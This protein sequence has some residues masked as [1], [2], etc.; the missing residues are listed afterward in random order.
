MGVRIPMVSKNIR[1]EKIVL[2]FRL[3]K[4]ELNALKRALW[5][6][7]LAG[8]PEF[9]VSKVGR[10]EVEVV[11]CGAVPPSE[12]VEKIRKE[13]LKE[14]L[15][16]RVG[17]LEKFAEKLGRRI[18][19][20]KK[21]ALRVFP[22]VAL[23]V[24]GRARTRWELSRK[25]ARALEL[26]MEDGRPDETAGLQ[27]ILELQ[28]LGLI[29]PG[30]R[31]G[32]RLTE[33]GREKLKEFASKG[34]DCGIEEAAEAL[35]GEE[36]GEG[37]EEGKAEYQKEE[38]QMIDAEKLSAVKR[39]AEEVIGDGLKAEH[40]ETLELFYPDKTLTIFEVAEKSG[41]THSGA[42]AILKRLKSRGFLSA[43]EA[44][45]GKLYYYLTPKGKLLMEGFAGAGA[46]EIL[47]LSYPDYLPVLF[48][49]KDGVYSVK[50]LSKALEL[51][52]NR[53]GSVLRRLRAAGLIRSLGFGDYKI[54]NKGLRVLNRAK[55]AGLWE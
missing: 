31:Y 10:E 49:S 22:K 23:C 43:S 53:V 1:K 45:R 15:K 38:Y 48:A 50:A 5:R 29:E 28:R 17:A 24:N 20:L 32:W 52:Y 7:K 2:K 13:V 39:R 27:I 30:G 40:L 51:D 18:Q 54:T 12:A 55:R 42:A 9:K 6:W 34:K 14:A 26:R 19:V 41:K 3:N 16:K 8:G 25:V 21:G 46:E 47:V 44:K 4:T 36:S 11:V 37:E 33:E 35:F